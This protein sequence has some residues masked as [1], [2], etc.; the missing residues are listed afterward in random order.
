M[1]MSYRIETDKQ[2]SR[3]TGSQCADFGEVMV[4]VGLY[5]W[6]WLVKS[7]SGWKSHFARTKAS[8]TRQHFHWNEHRFINVF[9]ARSH[10]SGNNKK[11]NANGLQSGSFVK[12]DQNCLHVNAKNT[13]QLWKRASP[14]QGTMNAC[15]LCI[16][17]R[18]IE[19]S[20]G[21]K[22]MAVVDSAYQFNWLLYLLNAAL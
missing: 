21:M 6:V 12:L 18:V 13:E 16:D 14:T 1:R 7:G 19:S 20:R 8:F 2:R 15:P 5:K 9:G 3:Y 22:I 11:K 4:G 10:R 17:G